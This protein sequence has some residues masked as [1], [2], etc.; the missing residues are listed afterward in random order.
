[1]KKSGILKGAVIFFAAIGLLLTL[2]A[3][4]LFVAH[5]S[6]LG[7]L[8]NLTLLLKTQALN[9]VDTSTLI[10]GAMRGMV[11]S[12]EDPYST[13]LNRQEFEDLTIRI[14]ASFGGIGVVVGA[15]EENRFRVVAPMK[16]TPAE[17]AGIKSRD[18][19]LRINGEP[20]RGMSLDEAVELMRGEPGTQVDIGIYRE[21]DKREYNFRLTREVINVPSVESRMLE[22]KPRIGYLHLL[23][24]SATSPREVEKTLKGFLDKGARGLILDLRDNPGGDFDAALKIAD[25]FLDKGTIVKVADHKGDEVVHQASPPALDLPMVV[26]VNQGSASSSEILAGALQDHHVAPLV[27]QKTFGKGL[28]QTVYPLVGGDA[29]KLTTDKYFTPD[30]TDINQIGIVPDYTVPNSNGGK[31]DPQFER[32]RELLEQRISSK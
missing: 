32:A 20:T 1:M 5:K 8:V 4:Y 28:V 15:D 16:G 23:Q 18:I 26:L 21:G 27:G 29:L 17:R 13:Y 24:F 7:S 31:T 12:L 30:G 3:G 22:G 19:I 11:N 14:Q 25:I 10:Q 2:S 9:P 6:T